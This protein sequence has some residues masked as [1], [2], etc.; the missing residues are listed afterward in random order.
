MGE[1]IAHVALNI[2]T[3]YFNVVTQPEVDFPLVTAAQ[4]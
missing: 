4:A 2:V 3:N 1:I